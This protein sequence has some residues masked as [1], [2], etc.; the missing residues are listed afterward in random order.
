VASEEGF[1]F[2]QELD[3]GH[4]CSVALQGEIGA[5]K[6]SRCRI[7]NGSRERIQVQ[8]VIGI[9]LVPAGLEMKIKD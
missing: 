6:L 3:F 7:L 4:W 9:S 5:R 1:V 8:R 2:V